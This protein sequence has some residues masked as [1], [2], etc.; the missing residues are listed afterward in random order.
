MT[1]QW[2][3]GESWPESGESEESGGAEP[4]FFRRPFFFFWQGFLRTLFTF[5]GR[6]QAADLVCQRRN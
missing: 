2:A 6:G 5:P 1:A 3:A 4:I